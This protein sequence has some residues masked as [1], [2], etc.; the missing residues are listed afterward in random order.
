MDILPENIKNVTWKPYKIGEIESIK[1]EDTT[2][3][4]YKI[5][6]TLNTKTLKVTAVYDSGYE[7]N[8]GVDLVDIQC[9][10]YI[11]GDRE[12]SVLYK[13]KTGKYNVYVHDIE[14]KTLDKSLYPESEHNYPDNCDDTKYISSPGVESM[15]ITFSKQTYLEPNIDFI[16]ITTNNGTYK[17]TGN[18]G[19]KTLTFN[20][21][22]L[23]IRLVSDSDANYYGYSFDS[24]TTKRTIHVPGEQAT[25]T[26]DQ[27]CIKCEKIIQKAYGHDLVPIEV[28]K[29]TLTKDGKTEGEKCSVCGVITKNKEQFQE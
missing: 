26:T 5:G 4:F 18:L 6:D 16:Y 23:S 1:C 15:S 29:A 3:R 20:T 17:Y 10:M 14:Y 25:C 13:G 28:E 9:D 8:I 24:I 22:S 7:E 11:P 19:G 12:V 27:K 2:N 21:D